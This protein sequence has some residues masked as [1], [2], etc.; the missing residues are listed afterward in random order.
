MKVEDV[1]KEVS[2]EESPEQDPNSDLA[3]SIQAQQT[4]PAQQFS[5]LESAL[6]SFIREY[7]KARRIDIIQAIHEI[8]ADYYKMLMYRNLRGDQFL[9]CIQL[10]SEIEE[11]FFVSLPARRARY[12]AQELAEAY[13]SAYLEL[14]ALASKAV[15]TSQAEEGQEKQKESNRL[16]AEILKLMALKFSDQIMEVAKREGYDQAMAKAL[17]DILIASVPSK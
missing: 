13:K 3:K 10:L 4:Q 5:Q 1:I 12:Q 9:A 6:P 7:A 14:L 2:E 16:L 17:L 15:D 8:T 11:R